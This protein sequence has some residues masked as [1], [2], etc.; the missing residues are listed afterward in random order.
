MA[1]YKEMQDFLMKELRLYHYPIAVYFFFD[2]EKLDEYIA[3]TDF[4]TPI[5]PVTYCQYEVQSRM[6]GHSVLG[7][8]ENMGCSNSLVSFGWNP[9]DDNEIKSHAKYTTDLDQA[10]RFLR[11][12]PRLKEGLIALATGPLGDAIMEPST[13]HFYVD[14]MQGYHLGVDY[15]AATNTH[16][17]RPMMTMNSAAC[18]GAAYSFMEQTFNFAPA[19]SG[20]YNAGKT[21]RGEINVFIPGSQIEAT[22]N[23]LKARV[24]DHGG[25]SITRPGDPLPGADVCKNCPLLIF[26]KGDKEIVEKRQEK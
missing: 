19:C 18:G 23:R 7:F 20:S 10:E 1:N 21:E 15:M 6:K 9:I 11:S 8:K 26:K 16:P 22:V 17:L 13:V 24:S 14:N 4:V 5:R 3:K 12:K 25:A 2:Q